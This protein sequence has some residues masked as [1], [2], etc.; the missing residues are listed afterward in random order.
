MYHGILHAY[1][2]VQIKFVYNIHNW[3]CSYLTIE[4][5][6]Y[7]IMHKDMPL[8][9]LSIYES[10]H[11]TWPTYCIRWFLCII[12]ILASLMFQNC[13]LSTIWFV[14]SDSIYHIHRYLSWTCF[15]NVKWSVC[16][17][18]SRFYVYIEYLN[19]YPV[20]S[21][22]NYIYSPNL[23]QLVGYLRVLRNYNWQ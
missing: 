16:I 10:M 14:K 17:N 13:K 5:S 18:W 19:I 22:P 1:T 23:F 8:L 4:F 9:W 12:I 7:L 20:Y 2:R 15:I 11:F 21:T 3:D 6:K